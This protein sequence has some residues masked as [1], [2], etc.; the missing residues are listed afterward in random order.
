MVGWVGFVGVVACRFLCNFRSTVMVL[1]SQKAGPS[2]I[3][4]VPSLMESFL[5]TALT[6]DRKEYVSPPGLPLWSCLLGMFFLFWYFGSVRTEG[7]AKN[8]PT[9]TSPVA[10]G[11]L[12]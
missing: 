1:I 4:A 11:S 6:V 8:G 2:F 12:F 10:G 7:R 5:H 3:A 9:S